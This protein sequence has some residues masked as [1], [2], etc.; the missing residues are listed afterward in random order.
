MKAYLCKTRVIVVVCVEREREKC[1][2]ILGDVF[3]TKN[4]PPNWAHYSYYN[5]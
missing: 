5:H 3:Y 4:A 2:K 1:W